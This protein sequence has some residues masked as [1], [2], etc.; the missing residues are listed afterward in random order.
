M[1]LFFRFFPILSLVFLL[2]SGNAA[3]FGANFAESFFSAISWFFSIISSLLFS[4][5]FIIYD[6]RKNKAYSGKLG[7]LVLNFLS[8]FFTLFL[9]VFLGSYAIFFIFFSLSLDYTASMI[10]VFTVFF[11]IFGRLF[12]SFSKERVKIR[13]YSFWSYLNWACLIVG[14]APIIV[15]NLI[16]FF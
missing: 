6:Y 1:K 8:L 11:G 7:I 14:L 9:A 13:F 3:A 5:G 12:L 2:S 10:P 15:L 4:V 16:K